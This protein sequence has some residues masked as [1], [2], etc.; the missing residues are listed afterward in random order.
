MDLEQEGSNL[1]SLNLAQLTS[2]VE[3][4]KLNDDPAVVEIDCEISS[5]VGSNIFVSEMVKTKQTA[6]KGA[7]FN[8]DRDNGKQ[9]HQGIPAR[10][11]HKGKPTGKAAMHMQ[12][13]QDEDYTPSEGDSSTHSV[14]SG[15]GVQQAV[16]A[17]RRRRTYGGKA[18]VYKKTPGTRRY[19]S[20]VG[21]LKEIAFYQREYGL[22]CSKIASARIFREICQDIKL[23]LRWQSSA[24][25]ALQEGYESYLV[26]LFEDCV[27]ECIH[28]KRKTVMPK[29]MHVAMRIR[30]EMDKYANCFKLTQPSKQR[31]APSDDTGVTQ[32]Y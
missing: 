5:H 19:K 18:R 29:D 8:E 7:N 16:A 31:A 15:G 26:A 25:L 27:L 22:L 24:C 23:D 3:G 32:E 13:G 4:L 2:S 17:A 10:F 20:G 9:P 28:G 12:A 6:R 11:P 14:A 1:K 21:A 30:G